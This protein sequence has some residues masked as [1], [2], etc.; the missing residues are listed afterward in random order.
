[1]IVLS[2]RNYKDWPH[3]KGF[4]DRIVKD[5]DGN[6]RYKANRVVV[7]LYRTKGVDLNVVWQAYTNGAFSLEEMMEFYRLIGYSLEGFEEIWHQK[8][9]KTRTPDPYEED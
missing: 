9:P 7:F 2:E 6:L 8:D 3:A 1:M 4:E 5:E